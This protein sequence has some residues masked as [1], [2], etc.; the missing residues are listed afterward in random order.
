MRVLQVIDSLSLGGAEVLLTAMH[1]GFRLRGIECEYFLLN[2]GNTPLEKKLT[3]QAARIYAPCRASV[4][5]PLHI[6]SLQRHLRKSEYDLLHVHLFPAQLWAAC[7]VRGV[8]TGIPLVTTEHSTHNRRRRPWYR[9]VDRWMYRQYGSIASISEAATSSLVAWLP[10]VK[11]KIGE[12]PNGIDFDSFASAFS[13]GKQAL[14]A[15]PQDVPVI[16]C[17][18]S[19]EVKKDHQTLLRAASLVPNVVVALAGD[20]PMLKQLRALADELGIAS[21]VQFLGRRFDVP[22][23]L[24]AADIY[25]QPSRWEGFGIAA[26][27]AMAAGLPTIVTNAPG[28]AQRVGNTGLLFPAGVAQELARCIETLLGDSQLRRRLASFAQDRARSFALKKTLDCY[29]MLYRDVVDKA[30]R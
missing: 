21:R 9:G 20:G 13:P 4:Y 1:A 7:A 11:G 28:L 5:S 6:L 12:C 26:L 16:L 30:V 14:F 3:S 19:L 22:Q 29:E 23:L 8:R 15:V 2:A 25:V 18:A 17:V 27:E 24:K 10:D